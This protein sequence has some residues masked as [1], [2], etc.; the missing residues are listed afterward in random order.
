MEKGD[1]IKKGILIAL[2]FSLLFPVIQ[3]HLNFIKVRPLKGAVKELEKP[4]FNIKQWFTGE[5]Q[6]EEEAYKNASFGFRNF[7]VRLNNQIAFSLFDKAN[8]KGVVVG[9]SNYLYEEQYILAYYGK[10][11]IGAD[12]IRHRLDRMKFL[13][14]TL[15][16]QNKSLI[17]VFAAGKG[18]YFPEY[19]P[20][21]YDKWVKG[22]T[23]YQGYLNYSKQIGLNYIDFNQYFI[24]KKSHSSYP[25]FPQYGIHW[26]NYGVCLAADS[27]IHYIERLRHINMPEI[28]WK[29]V[30]M[31]SPRGTDYDI[32]DGMNLLQTLSTYP[33][34]YPEVQYT[35]GSEEVRP[36]S[37]IIADSYYWGMY[38][39]GISNVFSNT[40]FWFYNNEVYSPQFSEMKSSHEMD[41]KEAINNHDIIIILCTEANMPR[42]G[43]GFI[44]Q[45]YDVYHDN[46]TTKIFNLEFWEKVKN[47]R[48]YIKS[49]PEI[50][51]GVIEKATARHISVDSMVTLDAIWMLQHQ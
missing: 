46:H 50:M 17:L 32:A 35:P 43:W 6:E 10:D 5:Y 12:S 41:L 1:K 3:T 42:L 23:N 15:A 20:H 34:A 51:S 38:N 19:F 28:Y 13:H 29:K 9:K 47:M 45:A 8:A 40:Q 14:D 11:F 4:K 48:A 2:L 24:N 18:S 36:A 30:D 31:D 44:E 25:L 26:S 33:M 7:F 16:K 22:Q 21:Q 39:I 27:M 49:K 37:L